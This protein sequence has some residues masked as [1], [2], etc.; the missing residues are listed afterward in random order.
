MLDEAR[1][2]EFYQPLH[3]VH[4]SG[5]LE[6]DD[7]MTPVGTT[8]CWMAANRALE[9]ERPDPLYRDP[10]ARELGGASGFAMMTVMRAVQSAPDTSAPDAYLTIR[11]K[12][13]DDGVLHATR[14]LSM[15]QVVILGAG[16]D[17]R[18]FRLDWPANLVLFEV[19]RGDVFDRKEPLLRRLNAQPAC[20]RRIVRADLSEPWTEALAEAGFDSSRPAAI[21]VE[22]LFMYLDQG[23]A[24]RL[25]TSAAMVCEGSWMGLD[26]V[27]TRMLESPYTA[28]YLKKLAEAG[29]PWQFGV[30]DPEGWLAGHG[31]HATA[32]TP[33]EPDAN[34][35]RWPY[36]VIPRSVGGMPRAY[37]MRATR[38]R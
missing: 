3:R 20:D 29:C 26:V 9:T 1:A 17:S 21:L 30:D 25:L 27:N 19:D 11:T 4:T 31:W 24:T 37:L 34:Y 18:A 8:A 13:L 2:R 5:K 23:A 12:F 7:G 15:R 38:T 16:M 32:L 36:P 33:G 28:V 6:H 10:L 35:G 22:G 14:E